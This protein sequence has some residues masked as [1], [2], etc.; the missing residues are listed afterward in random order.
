[1]ERNVLVD[2]SW[3]IGCLRRRIDPFRELE[4]SSFGYEFFSCGAVMTEVCRGVRVQRHYESMR[5]AFA[6]MC[7]VPTT[8]KIWSEATDLARNLAA[9]GVTMQITDLVIAVSALSVDAVVLT[10]DSDF[11][12]VPDLQVLDKLEE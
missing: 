5:S 1:M 10:L 9:R 12:Q 7:W 3:F 4:K 11:R 2:S 8:E 6:V